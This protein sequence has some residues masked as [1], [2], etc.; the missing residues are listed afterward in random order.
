[1]SEQNV[2]SVQT[3]DHFDRVRGGLEQVGMKTKAT[4]IRNAD[5]LVGNVQSYI[6]ETIR[7]DGGDTIFVEVANKD[8]NTR[9][10]L[11]PKVADTIF[12]QR[13]ALTK[14][15]RQRLGREQAAD[16]KAQGIQP[17]GGKPFR[18]VG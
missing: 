1:M 8:G 11:P 10:V 16:R 4:T 12:R 13:N 15:T 17:F 6:V 14:R 3:V 5:F 9:V 7:H 18:K 2:Q